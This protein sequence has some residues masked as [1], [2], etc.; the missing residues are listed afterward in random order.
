MN[1]E[2]Y[3]RRLSNGLTVLFE[4]RNL[5]TVAV[6]ASV[7]FASAFETIENKGV[8]HF[9]EH[10][11]FKG[12]KTRSSLEISR[13]IEK[14]GGILNAYTSEEITS[15]WN[16]LPSNHLSKGLS[17][18]SD[19]ILNPKFDP[20]EF[21]KEK[22]VIIEEIK[23]YHDNPSYY[24]PEKIKEL[25]YKK[26][27]SMSIAGTADIINRLRRDEVIALFKENYSTD[28]M[29][30]CVVGDADFQEVC[31]FGEK[32]PKKTRKAISYSPLKLNSESSERRKGIDQTHFIL[33][34]HSPNMKDKLRYANELFMAYLTSGMSSKLFQEVREKRGLAYSIS[35]DIDSGENYAYSTIHA[36]T[37][38]ESVK[39]VREIILDEI[40]K[41]SNLE[42]KDLNE[43]K[44]QLIGR[45]KL[46]QEKS[47][48]V[49][50][51]IMAEELI[52]KGIEE[53]YVFDK[54][55]MAV[56]LEEVKEMSKLKGYSSF[57]LLPE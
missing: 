3:K 51:E 27:F 49:M 38:K 10:L 16:M 52:G 43:I 48:N 9:L 39:K 54:R 41:V 45:E 50:N 19:L 6:S 56:K 8:S 42:N 44:E 7:K 21:E 14:L 17:I 24:V 53:H 33:G 25:L 1:P 11:M 2:F 35:G 46:N 55:I 28:K 15:Y 32:F 37:T 18:V 31:K 26:P 47:V 40:K 57:T 13:E 4:K 12:T 36:G 5:P 34:F 30:L 29:V 20:V 23:M 22:K